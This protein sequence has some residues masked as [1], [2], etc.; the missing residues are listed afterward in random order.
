MVQTT[1][2]ETDVVVALEVVILVDNNLRAKI[3][4]LL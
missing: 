3:V 1:I 4:Q 2:L